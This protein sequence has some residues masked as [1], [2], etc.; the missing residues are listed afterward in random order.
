MSGSLHCALH[1]D[2]EMGGPRYRTDASAKDPWGPLL[3]E[4][5]VG[6]GKKKAKK[7]SRRSKQVKLATKSAKHAA[8]DKVKSER[9]IP[10]P[11]RRKR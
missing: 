6:T 8:G 5:W 4:T 11:P 3:N 7:S 1:Q 9:S 10:K 2:W